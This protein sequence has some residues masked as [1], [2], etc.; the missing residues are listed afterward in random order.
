[1]IPY[2]HYRLLEGCLNCHALYATERFPE[3][4][5]KGTK[6]E[7]M[8]RSHYNKH[9]EEMEKK[10]TAEQTAPVSKE[11]LCAKM[12]EEDGGCC[13]GKKGPDGAA[14][15]DCPMGAEGGCCAQMK[16][17]DGKHGMEGADHEMM[18]ED[19]PLA[20]TGDCPMMKEEGA[21]APEGDTHAGH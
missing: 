3:I 10:G 9:A 2:L 15:E 1:V 20:K 12:S 14:M 21:A 13:A 11:A 5:G 7:A 6:H 4:A 19:C 16:S 18:K 8:M 17:H